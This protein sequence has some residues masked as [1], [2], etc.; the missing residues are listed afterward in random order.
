[1]RSDRSTWKWE[2]ECSTSNI[3]P[4]LSLTVWISESTVA[5]NRAG[6][7]TVTSQLS[8][9][10]S[11]HLANLSPSSTSHPRAHGHV[12]TSTSASTLTIMF[13][14]AEGLYCY[15]LKIDNYGTKI[16]N[17]FNSFISRQLLK[18]T[19]ILVPVLGFTWIIGLFAVGEEGRVFAYLFVLANVFQVRG[20]KLNV[21]LPV[22][23]QRQYDKSFWHS[24][25]RVCSYLCSMFWDTRRYME[26]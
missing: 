10:P 7:R 15:H 22:N 9:G 14:I 16:D 11:T 1:M 25:Y 13:F 5:H 8:H 12:I 2:S 3:L 21:S 4:F 23:Q 17:L 26:G 6:V 19:I 20:T 18:T 24:S